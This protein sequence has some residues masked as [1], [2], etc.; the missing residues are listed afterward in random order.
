MITAILLTLGLNHL[1]PPI[2]PTRYTA[3]ALEWEMLLCVIGQQLFK[4][5]GR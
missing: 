5:I 4:R 3:E 1:P 2:R